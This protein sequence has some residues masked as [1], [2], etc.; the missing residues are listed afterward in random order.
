M[1]ASLP[2]GNMRTEFWGYRFRTRIILP[3]LHKSRTLS[4]T[5]IN[6]QVSGSGVLGTP[7]PIAKSVTPSGM[8]EG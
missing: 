8:G 7:S 1:H 3:R 6:A 4:A 2:A 5:I